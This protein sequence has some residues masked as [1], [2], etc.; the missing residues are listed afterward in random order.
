MTSQRP[1]QQKLAK[2]QRHWEREEYDVSLAD[3]E[4]LLLAYP[5]NAQL[6]V[7][8]GN[9][10]QLQDKPAQSL[11]DARASLQQA[12][13]L[14][15][16]SPAAAIE[17]GYFLDAVEDDPQAAVKAFSDGIRAARRGLI[18]GL[19][20][21]ARAL[22]Q[23]DRRPEALT[24]LTEALYLADRGDSAEGGKTAATPVKGPFAAKIEDLLDE[25]LAKRSA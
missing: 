4:A 12:V 9:L 17:L 7:L 5:G 20:G 25:L 19:L 14:D 16:D 24:C 10:I 23:L 18:D 8:R 3:V 22:L 11:E 2:V 21:K 15:K 1:F 6:H 13:A